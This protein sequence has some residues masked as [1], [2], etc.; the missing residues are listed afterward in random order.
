[1]SMQSV[2]QEFIEID[3]LLEAQASRRYHNARSNHPDCRDPDHP[4]CPDCIPQGDDDEQ[5]SY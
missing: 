4:G 1:M 2:A 3:Y 5:D